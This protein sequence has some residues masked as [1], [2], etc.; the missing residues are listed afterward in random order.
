MGILLRQPLNEGVSHDF[1]GGCPPI[2]RKLTGRG[3][4]L[5][6][7]K[8]LIWRSASSPV[9]PYASSILVAR[10]PRLPAIKSSWPE[11]S[12]VQFACTSS[13]NRG[14]SAWAE[15][16]STSF[17]I[18][19][20]RCPLTVDPGYR[21]RATRVTHASHPF[22]R[23]SARPAL[24]VRSLPVRLPYAATRRGYESKC[25]RG[26]FGQYTHGTRL[27]LSVRSVVVSGRLP[28]SAA[29]VTWGDRGCRPPAAQDLFGAQAAGR[30]ARLPRRERKVSVL[31]GVH[32][33]P[34]SI[35]SQSD[36]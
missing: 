13:L 33:H 23:A 8:L 21:L 10:R 27:P 16:Q 29:A 7:S 35:A 12:I 5:R 24:S 28:S 22:A 32:Q 4:V 34:A 11:V 14:Q 18:L 25:G 1:K 36:L 17:S 15:S 6:S 3:C 2:Q 31:M 9:M 26:D 19:R 20:V 30:K